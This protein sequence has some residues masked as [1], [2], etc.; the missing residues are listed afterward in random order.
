MKSVLSFFISAAVIVLYAGCYT[1][2]APV[3]RND[4]DFAYD[5]DTTYDNGNTTVNNNYYLDDNYRQSRFR[6]SFNYY[7]PTY[8]SWISSYYYSYF[9]DSYWGM[10]HRPSWYYDPFFSYY[11]PYGCLYPSPYYDPWYSYYPHG[12]Y[13]SG[14]YQG[15]YN[16]PVY[17]NNPPSPNRPRGDGPSRDPQL[18]PRDRPIPAP[19]SPTETPSLGKD[20]N[21]R[22]RGPVEAI[23]V[24]SPETRRAPE[25]AWWEKLNTERPVRVADDARPTENEKGNRPVRENTPTYTPPL[26]N[27]PNPSTDDRPVHRPKN[28][29]PTYTPPRNSNPND[30][31]RPVERPK[32]NEQQYTPPVRHSTPGTEARPVERSHESRQPSYSPPRQSA[33][34]AQAPARSGGGSAPS[35]GNERKRD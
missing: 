18:E 22:P 2:L 11:S 30:D 32:R 8:S 28:N 20:T 21:V 23:P 1:E 6:V 34:P 10:Y 27:N 7:Y 26:N 15:Y 33:P 5:S 13:Y 25:K 17:A 35:G 19:S 4:N 24:K 14:Y 16:P 9:N 31:S 12:G 3:E 29:H